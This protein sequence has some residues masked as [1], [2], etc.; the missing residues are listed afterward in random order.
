MHLSIQVAG[1]AAVI[2]TH[3][4]LNKANALRVTCPPCNFSSSVA[5]IGAE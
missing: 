5:S 3:M 1:I 2:T 4:P